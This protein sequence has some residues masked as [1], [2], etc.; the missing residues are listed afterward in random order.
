MTDEQLVTDRQSASRG[1]DAARRAAEYYA[2]L[3]W[4]RQ[5]VPVRVSIP[6]R[7][8]GG[9]LETYYGIRYAHVRTR[10]AGELAVR[11]GLAKAGDEYA[12]DRYLLLG[13]LFRLFEKKVRVC[14][15][16]EQRYHLSFPGDAGRTWY[17]ACY[18]DERTPAEHV[19][20]GPMFVLTPTDSLDPEKSAVACEVE[21]L[22]PMTPESE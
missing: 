20:F 1:G 11:L 13:R 2:G 15:H 19:P 10:M 12:E 4:L 18:S 8:A 7:P 3:P 9:Q 6:T 14:D 17:V 21:D 22:D 5:V 16:W